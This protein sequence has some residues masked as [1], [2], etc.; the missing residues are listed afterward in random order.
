MPPNLAAGFLPV[1]LS[2]VSGMFPYNKNFPQ[3]YE[4]YS[5][6]P[7]ITAARK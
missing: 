7:Q 3:I 4:K 5:I 6:S 1:G 2:P